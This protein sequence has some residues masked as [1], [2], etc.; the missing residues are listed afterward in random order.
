MPLTDA[1]GGIANDSVSVM[2]SAG[3]SRRSNRFDER[4]RKAR[5]VID[6]G[7][8]RLWRYA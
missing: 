8:Q 2:R 6:E 4:L 3:A 1:A 5:G 7:H